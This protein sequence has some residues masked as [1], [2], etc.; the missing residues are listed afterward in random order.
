MRSFIWLESRPRS[1]RVAVGVGVPADDGD[2]ED[3]RARKAADGGLAGP[4]G[5]LLFLLAGDTIVFFATGRGC[6]AEPGCVLAGW[7][8]RRCRARRNRE[9]ALGNEPRQPHGFEDRHTQSV[10]PGTAGH[11]RR[12]RARGLMNGHQAVRGGVAGRSVLARAG[13]ALALGVCARG[14]Q[15]EREQKGEGDSPA[16]GTSRRPCTAGTSWRTSPP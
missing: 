6:G 9:R 7:A 4:V 3:A 10:G 15:R 8:A 16:G 2:R 13:E 1:A 12:G 11:R 5:A 14:D